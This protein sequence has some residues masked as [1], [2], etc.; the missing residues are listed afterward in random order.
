MVPMTQEGQLSAMILHV[1]D[2]SEAL[3][4]VAEIADAG[5]NAVFQQNGSY[6]ESPGDKYRDK[7]SAVFEHCVL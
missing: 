7:S 6:I 5:N 2:R 4:S 1:V 3:G